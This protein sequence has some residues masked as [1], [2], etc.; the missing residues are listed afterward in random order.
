MTEM[1]IQ[2]LLLDAGGG[3]VDQDLVMVEPRGLEV[4]AD[5]RT[6]QSPETYVGCRQSTGF[7]QEEVARFDQ[8]RVYTSPGRLPFNSWG[9]SGNWTLTGDAAVFER[10]WRAD[11]LPV[12]RARSEPR[13]GSII[14]GSVDS[15]P[16]LPRGR[17]RGGRSRE[18][19]GP[20][21]PSRTLSRA[22]MRTRLAPANVRI[23]L[24]RSVI[25]EAM[26]NHR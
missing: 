15:V 7:A 21:A 5:W 6:L 8:P 19:R 18:R 20:R 12:P 1:V 22:L 9:L 13:D 11:R 25:M 10:G 26:T 3:A 16:R 14:P 17:A 4:A 24:L 2:Q 23:D